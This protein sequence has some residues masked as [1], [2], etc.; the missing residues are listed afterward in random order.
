[1]PFLDNFLEHDRPKAI[2]LKKD[3]SYHFEI[4]QK[5]LN[6]CKLEKSSLH[7]EHA[8]TINSELKRMQGVST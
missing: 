3:I 1:M 5:Y 8:M 6:E 4:A 2:Q 7:F